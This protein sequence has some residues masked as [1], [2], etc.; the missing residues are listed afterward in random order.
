MKIMIYSRYIKFLRNICIKSDR[1]NLVALLN[2]VKDDV[3][4]Q[5]GGNLRKIFMDTKVRVVPGVTHPSALT[6]I[7]AYTVEEDELWRLDLLQCLLQVKEDQFEIRFDEEGEVTF[8]E[9]DISDMIH[10]VCTS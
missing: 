1:P 8:D 5:T 7:K 9:D 4:S 2:L 10:E 3:R 6:G